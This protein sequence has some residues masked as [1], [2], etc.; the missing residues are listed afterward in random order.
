[1]IRDYTDK[2]TGPIFAL[3][4]KNPEWDAEEWLG[5]FLATGTTWV[6]EAD[7]CVVGFLIS[8][9]FKQMPY[10]SELFVDDK[11]RR[12]GIASALI[13]KF[14]EHN[15]SCRTAHLHVRQDN[16]EAQHLYR[17]FGYHDSGIEENFYGEGIHG[18]V[19][20]KEL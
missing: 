6:A 19:M 7:G 5:W 3:C 13:R 16:V 10:L 2:D 18:L 12:R 20:T 14:E 9:R 17:A 1:M 11:Y 15:Y 4:R 8:N